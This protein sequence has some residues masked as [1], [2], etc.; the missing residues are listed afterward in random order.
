MIFFGLKSLRRTE[1]D[2]GAMGVDKDAFLDYF[3]R[4]LTGSIRRAGVER[5][6]DPK[7]VHSIIAK[8]HNKEWTAGLSEPAMVAELAA[9]ED[10]AEGAR[11]PPPAEALP[12]A[13]P[14]SRVGSTLPQ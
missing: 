11:V 14:V 2:A 9:L 10:G 4:K 1:A 3:E 5:V 13:A 8:F 6:L 7:A 12:A